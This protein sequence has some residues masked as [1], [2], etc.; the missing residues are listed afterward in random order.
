MTDA[1]I[2]SIFAHSWQRAK[3]EHTCWLCGDT[4]Q[5]GQRYF[6]TGGTVNGKF[7]KVKHCREKCEI[8]SDILDQNPNL[9]LLA[10]Q[11]TLNIQPITDEDHDL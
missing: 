10:D 1:P 2:V 9:A 7:F 5:I 6:Q 4:I 11:V 8:T 3:K